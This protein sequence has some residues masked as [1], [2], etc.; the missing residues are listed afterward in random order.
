VTP[1]TC[2]RQAS[3]VRKRLEQ[4]VKSF[5]GGD[6]ADEQH[7]IA[8]RTRIGP[9]PGRVGSTE[10]G[11]RSVEWCVESLGGVIGHG[12]ERIEQ[13]RQQTRPSAAPEPMIGHADRYLPEA[14]ENGRPSGWCRPHLVRVDDVG[15][16]D[17]RAE[18]DGFGMNWM[19]LE[20][21]QCG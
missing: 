20:A 18:T 8:D 10:D 6:A 16:G 2:D 21:E 4:T 9:K 12:E 15:T 3:V 13:P 7:P 17:G 5:V 19:T 1:R 14:R 11:A